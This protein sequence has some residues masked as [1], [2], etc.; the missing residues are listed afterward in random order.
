MH[1][2]NKIGNLSVAAVGASV[3]VLGASLPAVATT[4]SGPEHASSL[5]VRVLIAGAN[6]HHTFTPEGSGKA[7]SEPLTQPDD[8]AWLDG[9]VFV[10]FQNAVGPQGT[11]S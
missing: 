1:L 7:K 8:I 4:R 2:K 6:R 3:L 11:P 5:R 10:T 9:N